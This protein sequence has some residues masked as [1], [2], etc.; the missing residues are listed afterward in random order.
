[1]PI[2]A[3]AAGAAVAWAE[4]LQAGRAVEEFTLGPANLEDVYVALV[5]ENSAGRPPESGEVD[6][7][8]A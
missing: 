5:G 8:A 1:M 7:A 2:P 6:G 3:D 4:S